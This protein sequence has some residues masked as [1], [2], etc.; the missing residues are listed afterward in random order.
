MS[1]RV[2]YIGRSFSIREHIDPD[3]MNIPSFVVEPVALYVL[4]SSDRSVSHAQ[5]ALNGVL[6]DHGHSPYNSRLFPFDLSII[7]GFDTLGSYCMI[8]F[9]RDQPLSGEPT[10]F[11]TP[12]IVLPSEGISHISPEGIHRLAE[13]IFYPLTPEGIPL[14][15]IT[16]PTQSLQPGEGTDSNFVRYFEQ[17]VCIPEFNIEIAAAAEELADTSGR[18]QLIEEYKRILTAYEFEQDVPVNPPVEKTFSLETFL[19]REQ[20]ILAQFRTQHLKHSPSSPSQ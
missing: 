7:G 5:I 15:E 4:P 18:P 20:E 3:N 2:N 19:A 8:G 14:P 16:D 6:R 11:F 9:K 13:R 17:H 10:T 12:H 1:T